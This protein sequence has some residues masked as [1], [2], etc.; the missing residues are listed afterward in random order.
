M[1]AIIAL[2]MMGWV[3][4]TWNMT[5]EEKEELSKYIQENGFLGHDDFS[6]KAHT[7]AGFGFDIN[8]Y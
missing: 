1:A 2:T 7:F 5:D 3:Q 4:A 6:L 8:T